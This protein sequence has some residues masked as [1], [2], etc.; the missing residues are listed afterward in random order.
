M[1]D[2]VVNPVFVFNSFENYKE[3]CNLL[4]SKRISHTDFE[5]LAADEYNVE[6]YYRFSFEK[7]KQIY[8]CIYNL[9]KYR[10]T[11]RKSR[12]TYRKSREKEFE[13]TSKFKE[14]VNDRKDMDLVATLY[15]DMLTSE[16]ATNQNCRAYH[17]A[18]QMVTK[19]LFG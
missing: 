15:G 17:K 19:E 16:S 5:D 10:E 2:Y 1:K 7:F 12:E 18:Q 11:Y 8:N 4:D 6:V 9:E 14:S 3:F 13:A